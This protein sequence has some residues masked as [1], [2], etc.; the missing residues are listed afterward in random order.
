MKINQIQWVFFD[1]G[2]TLVDESFAL[3]T[4]FKKTIE[5]HDISYD[6]FVSKIDEYTRLG[7]HGYR[8]ACKYYGLETKPWSSDKERLYCDTIE[9]LENLSKKVKLGII[10]NQLPGL[11][12]RLIKLKIA[13]YFEVIVSSSDVQLE[14]PDHK[15]FE[16]A[17]HDAK[18]ESNEAI[19][20]GDRIDNDIL[21]AKQLGMNAIWVQRDFE[22]TD[23]GNLADKHVTSLREIIEIFVS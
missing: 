19:M 4:Q 2:S 11:K 23:I 14:K 22:M 8:E 1:I 15:I 13:D 10:A 20:I 5:K 16:I 18:C 12:E 9:V 21:P 3:E 17:L 7:K 6:E